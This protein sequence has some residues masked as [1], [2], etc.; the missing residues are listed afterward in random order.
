MGDVG[1]QTFLTVANIHFSSK[2]FMALLYKA[3][4]LLRHG[5]GYVCSRWL[6]GFL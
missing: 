2:L 5:Q 1:H 3:M 4:T 6:W